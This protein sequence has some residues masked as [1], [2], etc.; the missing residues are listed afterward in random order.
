MG[1]TAIEWCDKVWNPITGCTKISE[2][3]RNCY[4]ERVAKRFWGE[5]KFS[6]VRCHAERLEQPLHWRR[7]Q[8]VFV[9]SMSDLFHEDVPNEFI[10]RIFAAMAL[11]PQHQFQILTKRPERM[12]E[13][14]SA[15]AG[16]EVRVSLAITR[17]PLWDRGL[18]SE[19]TVAMIEDLMAKGLLPNVWLGVSVEDQET[20]DE[21]IPILLQTPAAVR[22]L[23]VEPILGPIVLEG[24]TESESV[25]NPGKHAP[26]AYLRHGISWTACG[27][28]SGRNA[29]PM[30]P[31]WVRSLR[32]QCQVAGVPFFFKQWGE[33]APVS[34]VGAS[35]RHFHFED[36]IT[37]RRV[38]KKVAGRMLDG[39][40]WN[41]FP[42][43]TL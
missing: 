9:N 27:G 13:Y 16:R 23:S 10:D 21:R 28:E 41:E 11:C 5:R 24:Y 15:L 3:C 39:R 33:W 29:R 35:R 31:D 32:D 43:V 34:G 30:H 37:M 4:A 14:C 1:K 36:G 19:R 7:P 40:E 22:W 42:E 8:R 2:G 38:G 18:A 26:R 17:T 25:S 20:A 6:E 12:A